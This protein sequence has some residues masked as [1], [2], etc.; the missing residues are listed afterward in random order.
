MK[1]NLLDQEINEI[2]INCVN[3]YILENTNI[4]YCYPGW[5]SDFNS[6]NQ[7]DIDNGENRT[8]LNNAKNVSN[9]GIMYSNDN[10]TN[11]SE[12][13]VEVIIIIIGFALLFFTFVIGII[14]CLY[15][16]WKDIKLVKER[17]KYEKKRN[18][19]RNS[20]MYFKRD[21]IFYGKKSSNECADTS[22]FSKCN[23]I[24]EMKDLNAIDERIKK[25]KNNNISI[26][27]NRLGSLE[28]ISERTEA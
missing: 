8:K 11:Y 9:S 5:T 3:G 15:K 21:E 25:N 28:S 6:I 27:V 7:C 19:G 16:K 2:L 12:M 10:N 4:C 22:N 24:I 14:L 23:S 17:I 1:R 26:E 20:D 18:K 13:S